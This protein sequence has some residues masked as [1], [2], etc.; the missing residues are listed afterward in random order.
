MSFIDAQHITDVLKETVFI[1][2]TMHTKEMS[3]TV[4]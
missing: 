3:A 1:I 2:H 4:F